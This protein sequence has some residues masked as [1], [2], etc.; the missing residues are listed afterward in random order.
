M[1]TG[2]TITLIIWTFVGKVMSLLF[3][4]QS[5]FVIAFL[6]RSK[7]LIVSGLQ[8]LSIVIYIYIYMC[9]RILF[10][11]KKEKISPFVVV[12]MDLVYIM[13]SEINQTEKDKYNLISV[14]S[15]ILKNNN[16]QTLKNI[17]T[18]KAHTQKSSS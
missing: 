12:W 16:K 6:Q 15:G 13:L 11:H 8:S 1:T 4:M 2:K 14:I 7:H 3:D 18:K 10:C 9:N 17:D 5:R